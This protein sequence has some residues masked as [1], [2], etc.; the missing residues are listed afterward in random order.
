MNKH[1]LFP[2]AALAAGLVLSGCAT[3]GTSG[4]A[5]PSA[6][7]RS[8]RASQ[9]PDAEAS[10]NS[11]DTMFAQMMIPHHEQAVVMSSMM[12]DKEDLDPRITELAREIKAAQGPEIQQMED[13]L[14]AWNEPRA[15]L[16]GHSM[17]M[18]GML[19]EDQLA[20]L[21]QARGPEA[22]RLFLTGMIAHHEGAVEM[23]EEEIA[24]GKD[25]GA[26]ELAETIA[27]TQKAEIV[28]MQALLQDL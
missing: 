23:A 24:A 14:E 13:W 21:E 20:A 9:S 1:A 25:A 8:H 12:L 16:K 7:G 28:R 19:G 4:S 18:D 10:H 26:V 15:P 27:A 5:S 3:P 11:A 17:A 2:T 6:D 22:A